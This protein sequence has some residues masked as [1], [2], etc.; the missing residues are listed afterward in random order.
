MELPV[1]LPAEVARIWNIRADEN[2]WTW[3]PRVLRELNKVDTG[4]LSSQEEAY[5]EKKKAE[6]RMNEAK[7]EKDEAKVEKDDAK[8]KLEDAV[9]RNVP[10]GQ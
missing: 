2:D 1:Y 3:W 9:R 7:V 6:A 8:S 4:G 10:S 5:L